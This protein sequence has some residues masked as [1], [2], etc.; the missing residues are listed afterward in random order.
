[1]IARGDFYQL[2]PIQYRPVYV[3]FDDG[4]LNISHSWR[5]FKIAELTEVMRQRGDQTLI[6]LLNNVRTGNITNNDEKIL[7]TKF[8]EKSDHN[9]YIRKLFTH[10]QKMLL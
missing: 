2:P 3:E 4:M 7:Q 9:Y 10:G 8:M 1:M 5:L 6:T